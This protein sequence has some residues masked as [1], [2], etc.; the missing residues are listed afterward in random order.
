MIMLSS[1]RRNVFDRL[2]TLKNKSPM[3]KYWEEL[4]KTQYLSL[5]ELQE[6]QWRRLQKLYTFLWEKNSFYRSRFQNVGLD[7]KFINRTSRYR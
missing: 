7:P 2:Y 3:R 1:I 4:E 5:Q 6:I